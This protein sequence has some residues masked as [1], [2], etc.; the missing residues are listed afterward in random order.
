M[1]CRSKGKLFNDITAD[2]AK[3]VNKLLLAGGAYEMCPKK[4]WARFIR[5]K[6]L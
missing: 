5:N 3:F 2:V 4:I 6:F 1:H